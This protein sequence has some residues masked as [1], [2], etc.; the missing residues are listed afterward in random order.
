MPLLIVNNLSKFQENIFSNNR[1]IEKHHWFCM[2]TTQMTQL[3][4]LFIYMVHKG[5]QMTDWLTEVKCCFWHYFN[6]WYI[7]GPSAPI[8]AFLK[9]LLP[10]LHTICFWRHWLL[11]QI[12]IMET[13]IS[14]ERWMNHVA[15]NQTL[16][17]NRPSQESN[18]QPPDLKSCSKVPFQVLFPSPV[19]K[20]CSQVLFLNPLLKSRSQVL[21][22]TV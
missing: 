20:S 9:V 18:Q 22:S 19:L 10:V 15:I 17:R 6:Y 8:H 1:D 3:I 7:M 2:T 21:H 16:V 5:K 13:T 14:S 12:S 4:K 11:S